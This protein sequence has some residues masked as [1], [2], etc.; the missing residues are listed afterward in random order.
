MKFTPAQQ[1]AI[2]SNGQNILVAAAAGSGKTAVL[3]ERIIQKILQ[4]QASVDE[5]VVL[6][7]TN[8]AAAQMRQ[9]IRTRLEQVVETSEGEMKHYLQQQLQLLNQAQIST[10]HAFC[11]QVLREHYYAIELDPQFRIG[12]E[13]ELA[14]LQNQAMETTLEHAYADMTPAFQTFVDAYSGDRG[15]ESIQTL[16]YQVVRFYQSLVDHDA[17]EAKTLA[18][19]EITA[20]FATT[21]IG[22]QMIKA[23]NEQVGTWLTKMQQAQ[24]AV[25]PDEKNAAKVQAIIQAYVQVLTTHQQALNGGNWSTIMES[26]QAVNVERWPAKGA[27][28]AKLLVDDLKKAW[29]K[30]VETYAVTQAD[31]NEQATTIS[32][33]LQTL[34]T[35]ANAYREEFAHLKRQRNLVDFSDLEQKT[36]AILQ[37]EPAIREQYQQRIHE[38]LVDEYQDTNEVQETIVKLCSN[39]RNMFMVGDVKQSIYRFRS[40]D[41]G[42]FQAKY[43][44]YA[45]Q[46]TREQRI[47][48][49]QNFRS[50]TSVIDFINYTF[51]QLMDQTFGEID[52][53]E[54]AQLHSG[55]TY[56][57]S[58]AM[59]VEVEVLLS[60]E[61]GEKVENQAHYLVQKIQSL[62][63]S[64]L[65][66]SAAGHV[67][68][69]RYADIVIL[70]RTRSELFGRVSELL[71]VAEIPYVAQEQGGYFDA[72]E[73]RNLLSVLRIIDNPFDDIEYAS[74][75]RS[76]IIGCDEN[77][78]LSIR[79]Q[80]PD[81]ALCQALTHCLKQADVSPELRQ[82][83]QTAVDFEQRWRVSVKQQPLAQWI[84]QVLLE[85]G[86]Y[87]FV[88]GLPNGIHRQAN[89]DALIEKART[90]EA[91]GFRSLFKFNRFIVMMQKQNQDFTNLRSISEQENVVQL[92]TI[93][94]SKGLEFPVVIVAEL[95]KGFN[96]QD[97]SQMLALD[98][99]HGASLLYVDEAK[100][101]R[102]R[103]LIQTWLNEQGEAAQLAEG[104]R[105]LY[106]ALTRAQEKLILVA[107]L[108]KTLEKLQVQFSS[109][110]D[111]KT[112]RLPADVRKDANST[113]EWVWSALIRHS[114]LRMYQ[115]H[116]PVVGPEVG[117]VPLELQIQHYEQSFI[118]EADETQV[119]SGLYQQLASGE[120]L[121]PTPNPLVEQAL[122]FSYPRLAA[123]QHYA[124][125]SISD[126]KRMATQTADDIPLALF[127]SISGDV[128][129]TSEPLALPSFLAAPQSQFGLERGNAYHGLMQH[130][131]QAVEREYQSVKTYIETSVPEHQR[132]LLNPA[133]IVNFLRSP[134]GRN[135]Q[136]AEVVQRELPFSILRSASSLYVDWSEM[137]EAILMRGIFDAI[138][139]LDEEIVLVDYKTDAVGTFDEHVKAKLRE[140]YRIQ[141]QTYL[142]AATQLYGTKKPIRG[143]LYFFQAQHSLTFTIQNL[144]EKI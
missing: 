22:N 127:G 77:D 108:D 91:I 94:K 8:A 143:E 103:S 120:A 132:E 121:A 106:V 59:A 25:D 118:A 93:H 5:L 36:L 34:F 41:P 144:E 6:T 18:N 109:I 9:R 71:K 4:C 110:L 31:L 1:Q 107:Q 80:T 75:L 10:F 137:E 3:V 89:I 119:H 19:Y 48:L 60:E 116:L 7:F 15:D 129:A 35:L 12:D 97:S 54:A 86:Y 135:F 117:A 56:P 44:D 133:W 112:P 55:A 123:T 83:L 85:T 115:S 21:A 69:I 136:E 140:R 2:E 141:M 42:L 122:S 37:N 14:L 47:D 61:K 101:Y 30:Y 139:H 45:K 99:H 73:I 29:Q 128:S 16:I 74:W 65:L 38:L 78:L 130:L 26:L 88:G 64:E 28:L 95:H 79:L 23:M 52:Y 76:P 11:I 98:K 58:S 68:P 13:F 24:N 131:P 32:K 124:A 84:E 17:F 53:D 43:Q 100:N 72:S 111:V 113:F 49:N 51:G 50:R 27:P 70:F 66:V 126:L 67:R 87:D 105:I 46:E 33:Q 134:L 82:K 57:E 138:Y 125:L 20:N 104:L 62:I 102:V 142:I 92:M 39:G 96:K 90:Y 114:K 81:V 63:A 40:A